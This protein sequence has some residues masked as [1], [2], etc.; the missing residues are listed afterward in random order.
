ML[1]SHEGAACLSKYRDTWATEYSISSAAAALSASTAC[2]LRQASFQI[3]WADDRTSGRIGLPASSISLSHHVSR[4]VDR[5]INHT[6]D[7]LANQNGCCRS[8]RQLLCRRERLDVGILDGKP[9]RIETKEAQLRGFR[10]RADARH[11]TMPDLS[12]K[13]SEVRITAADNRRSV[14]R[15]FPRPTRAFLFSGLHVEVILISGTEQNAAVRCIR[16]ELA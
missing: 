12:A 7:G 6:C 13:G 2:V 11:R 8:R 1:R 9:D 5:D 4:F 15:S 3:S 10:R 16:F 14:S